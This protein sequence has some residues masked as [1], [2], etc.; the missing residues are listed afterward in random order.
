MKKKIIIALLSVICVFSTIFAIGNNKTI[1]Q[2]S[3]VNVTFGQNDM[4]VTTKKFTVSPNTFEA[5][6][7]LPTSVANDT[8]G[9]VIFGNY[10]DTT[11][12]IT[13]CISFEVFT[14]GQP[15]MYFRN[16]QG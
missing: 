15:R 4:L 3:A 13:N 11:G 5:T 12:S 6:I 8:R 14:N 7:N 2:V 9:G 1:N 10:N 16:N